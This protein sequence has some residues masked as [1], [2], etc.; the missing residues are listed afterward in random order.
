MASALRNQFYVG[1]HR[2]VMIDAKAQKDAASD[3]FYFR[4]LIA[5]G[6][7]EQALKGIPANAPA[8]L[9]VLKLWAT[10]RTA[11]D[12]NKELVL[13]KVKETKDYSPEATANALNV[14]L[15]L[16]LLF[17]EAKN[18]REAI[19]Y[20]H[21]SHESLEHLAVTVQV[22]LRIDRA[23]LA[24][25]QVKAMQDIDDDDAITTL[26]TAWLHIAVGGDKLTEAFQLLEELVQKFGNS[27][28]ILNTMAVCQMGLKN[29]MKAF[30]L[31]KQARELALVSKDKLA[32]ETL[33]NS[34]VCLQHL[35]KA[36]E[37]VA[38][39]VGELKSTYPA[40]PWIVRYTAV[41]SLF[42]KTAA[43]YS[44]KK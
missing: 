33:I 37:L 41:E 14:S 19:K 4:S 40:H 16:A 39:I 44:A 12:E 25:K 23:D 43:T 32:P 29:W 15:A 5:L 21:K 38:R 20:V 18:L 35:H 30:G 9:Q 2:K 27:V 3:F 6:Q 28:D 31:L 17:M 26:A 42:D 1:Q 11:S 8:E 22:Y 7:E 24:G 36:P 34:I 10:Y 13:E